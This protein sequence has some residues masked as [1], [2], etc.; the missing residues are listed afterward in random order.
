MTNKNMKI[1]ADILRRRHVEQAAKLVHRRK[2]GL[3]PDTVNHSARII[4]VLPY[5]EG[6]K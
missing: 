3:E 4:G 6:T 1:Y 2:K 5:K